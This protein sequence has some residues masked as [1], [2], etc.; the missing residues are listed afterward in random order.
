MEKAI[1]L[2][3][4]EEASEFS[5]ESNATMENYNI[6]PAFCSKDGEELLNRIKA[7]ADAEPTNPQPIIAI[8][9]KLT[10]SIV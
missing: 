2:I 5:Q 3:I 6:T 10:L 7:K 1:K 8:F 9:L 4:T